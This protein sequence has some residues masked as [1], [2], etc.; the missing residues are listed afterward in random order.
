VGKKLF[1]S[2]E[3]PRSRSQ[4][5]L[6]WTHTDHFSIE[7]DAHRGLPAAGRDT[8]E[9]E[10]LCSEVFIQ[11]LGVVW[12][13]RGSEVIKRTQGKVPAATLLDLHRSFDL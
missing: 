7:R 12:L 2:S 13:R 11:V 1:E 5:Q 6:L 10:R 4:Q 8:S 3:G 9:M